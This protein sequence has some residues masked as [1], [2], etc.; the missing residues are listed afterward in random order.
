MTLEARLQLLYLA[1]PCFICR[2]MGKAGTVLCEHREWD[3]DMAYLEVEDR[4]RVTYE[5]QRKPV[6]RE[7]RARKART[8]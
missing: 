7:G 2:E 6:A 1:H 4:P 5:S 3:V 8:G